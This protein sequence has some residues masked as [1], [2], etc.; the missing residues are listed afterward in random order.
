M[1]KV[2]C[3]FFIDLAQVQRTSLFIQ[4]DAASTMAKPACLNKFSDNK[5]E[6]V[7]DDCFGDVA[8]GLICVSF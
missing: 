3:V 4:P 6:F 1:F 2:C 8:C 5:P 7:A